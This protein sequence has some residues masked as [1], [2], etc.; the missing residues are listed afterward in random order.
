[1]NY[2]LEFVDQ[3]VA[4]SRLP[5][6]E[7]LNESAKVNDTLK[8]RIGRGGIQK[9]RYMVAAMLVPAFDA[10]FKATARDIADSRAARTMIAIEKFQRRERRFPNDL[11]ELVPTFLSSVPLDPFDDK[12]LRYVASPTNCKVYSIGQNRKDDGGQAA[13]NQDSAWTLERRAN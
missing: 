4:A 13:E 6:P 1:V 8:D 11:T 10:A 2:Y 3:A 7:A 5:Y 9:T 12:P